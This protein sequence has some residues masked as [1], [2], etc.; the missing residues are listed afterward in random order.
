MRFPHS[1]FL[2]AFSAVAVSGQPTAAD[3]SAT[4]EVRRTSA[5]RTAAASIPLSVNSSSR[6]EVR[7]FYRAIYPL[8]ENVPLGW[9][10]SYSATNPIVAAGDTSTAFKDSVALRI[11]FFRALAGVPAGITLNSTY[12]AK[13]QQAALMMSANNTLQHDT[14]SSRIPTS[15]T[16]YTAAGA[17]ASSSSNLPLGLYGAAAITS[18]MQDSDGSG[19]I[20][21]GA[22]ARVGHRRWILYPQT[23]EM[24]TGDVPGNGSN[25]QAAHASWIVDTKFGQA[26]PTTR[27]NFVAYPPAGFVPYQLVW[28]RWSFSIPNVDF[29]AASV[30]M[31]RNGVAVPV[32]L[33]S[34]GDGA[35]EN[36][37]VWV[38]NNLSTAESTGHPRPA[39]DTTYTVTITG[40]K[41]GVAVLTPATYTVT[42]FDPDVAGP[43]ASITTVVGSSTP[44][45]AVA[46][47]Y[48]VAKAAFTSG[49]EWRT[50]AL[51]TF[52]K[53]YNAESGLDGL[54]GT[55]TTGAPATVQTAIFARGT[56]AYRLAHVPRPNNLPPETQFLTLPHTFLIN[57]GS[58]FS[59][60]SFLNVAASTQTARVQLSIDEG[61]TWTDLYTQAGSSPT[62][63][64]T[65]PPSD[66]GFTSRSI[67]LNPYV[68]RTVRLRL[69]FTIDP[70]P[71]FP[72]AEGNPVG[73]FIDDITL[74][75]A[76]TVTPTAPVTVAAGST[77]SLTPAANG[78]L[79][80]Q[81]RGL[82]FGAYPAE[83]GTVNQVTAVPP[84]AAANPG[85]LINLSVLTGISAPGD[86]FTLG[87][88]V[89]G[90][91]TGGSKPLVIR[92]A[93]PSLGALGVPGTL[94]DP[95]LETFAGATSTGVNDNWGGSTALTNALAAVGAFAYTGPTSKDAAVAA[96]ITT[97]DNS[98]AVSGVGSG[99]GAVIAEIYDAT[100]SAAF[101]T[102]TPRLLNVSVRKH[103]G[104]SLTAGFVVGGATPARIL[105]RAVGPG[106]AAF[107]VPDT[108][109][110]PQLTLF[111]GSSVKIAENNDWAGTPDLTA[112][113][114][115]VG[116]FALPAPTSKDA[117]LVL[118]LQPGSYSVQV[119]GV[120]DT[121]GVA[122]VE[123][124]EVP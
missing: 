92:A 98:V 71:A 3:F 73:W 41:L 99:T 53:T 26:R 69:A 68:G 9:T 110:D 4:S 106:L 45:T 90:P 2:L 58:T 39:A 48:T 55:V 7:Q 77:F 40:A 23:V 115:A 10:G 75:N 101:T 33:E 34:V 18:L 91:G 96:N 111:N 79:G 8:S 64:T 84:G 6:E 114:N 66:T 28:P 27:N 120:N 61:S 52:A 42:V 119:S 50:V 47:T 54:V 112:A 108:V 87:Y 80:L 17:E 62:N 15:W 67:S 100:S 60:L 97:R 59:F 19:N 30:T 121:T 72:G 11:N 63:T 94:D 29:S 78:P 102:S 21:L 70:G 43:D 118:T 25:L 57:P 107:G 36:T 109:V 16:F 56:A 103:L 104:T 65:P 46:S 76:Q 122:L 113:F 12:N 20:I 22:N 85:R 13:D 49:F 93:G 32:R 88:V 89:G 81:A 82:F 123:V 35:G 116:A 83:W 74:T 95:K 117:A 105:I 37:L 51:G 5:P 31:T 38:Y 124:Y 44:T 24:G 14:A 1:S 86:S